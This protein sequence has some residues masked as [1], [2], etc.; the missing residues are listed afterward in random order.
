MKLPLESED[1]FID[2]FKNN[3]KTRDIQGHGAKVHSVDWNCDGRRLASGS[4]DKMVAVYNLERD[5]LTKE[6]LFRGHTESVDQLCWHPKLPDV[7][8]TASL[9]KSVRFWDVSV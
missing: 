1:D 6:T 9:D 2:R 5:R 7:L 3:S 8:G 4:Y